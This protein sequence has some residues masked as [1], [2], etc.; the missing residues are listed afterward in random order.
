[1]VETCSVLL[2]VNVVFILVVP[3]KAI[4][5]EL[6]LEFN[7]SFATVRSAHM[8]LVNIGVAMFV[9]LLETPSSSSYQENPLMN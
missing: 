9:D 5:P 7:V 8:A 4:K 3:N 1:V 6:G 2:A